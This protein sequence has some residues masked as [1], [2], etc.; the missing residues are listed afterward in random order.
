MDGEKKCAVN[1]YDASVKK[2]K[3]VPIWLPIVVVVAVLAIVTGVIVYSNSPAQRLKKQLALGDRYLFD[4][5]YEEAID[6]FTAALEI[7]PKNKE[8]KTGLTESSLELAEE[9]IE[10]GNTKKA[11]KILKKA[12]DL[13]DDQSLVD[14]IEELGGPAE[15]YDVVMDKI[16]QSLERSDSRLNIA[17]ASD[18]NGIAWWFFFD[19]S[20]G[21][22]IKLYEL[23]DAAENQSQ[24][25]E[26]RDFS[27]Y[28]EK[29]KEDPLINNDFELCYES[30]SD[31]NNHWYLHDNTNRNRVTMKDLIR[32]AKDYRVELFV[33]D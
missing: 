33:L 19:Y 14:R 4:L 32:V 30:D 28:E 6:A 13:T 18:D 20:D 12:Y 9:L 21:Y 27:A 7:D 24:K 10:D 17:V 11:R 22:G 1:T 23:M 8:A 16:M 2:K 31:G 26:F 5:K 3:G 25:S 29:T 15:D